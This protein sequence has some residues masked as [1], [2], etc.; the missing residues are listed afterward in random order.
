MKTSPLIAL[1]ILAVGVALL[2]WGFNA[3]ESFAS[4]VSEVFN[5]APS[6][7]S[8]ILLVLGGL[9]TALGLIALL[10]GSK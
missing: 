2:I 8:I 7:K 10:R 1:V 4:G 5:D 6:D 3:K 9:V